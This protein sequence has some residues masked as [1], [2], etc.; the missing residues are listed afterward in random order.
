[1]QTFI[2]T[3]LIVFFI[4]PVAGQV[5]NK[6]NK[7]KGI[8]GCINRYNLTPEQRLNE[9]PFDQARQIQLVS[10]SQQEDTGNTMLSSIPIKNDT[11]SLSRVKRI[12]TLNKSQID[13]LTNILFNVGSK[14]N[15]YTFSVSTALGLDGGIVF[16]N[17]KNKIFEYINI[18]FDCRE[19]EIMTSKVRKS[20]G[21]PCIEK[22]GILKLFFIESGL[23]F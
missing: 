2:L 11:L 22:M 7:P 5:K 3:I 6:I 1:M 16:I 17:S 14:G 13:K 20:V 19:I 18:C 12:V 21:L 8:T 4:Q 9:Y 15:K 23:T 10:F